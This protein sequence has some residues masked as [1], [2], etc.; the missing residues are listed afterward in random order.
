MAPLTCVLPV[1]L[2]ETETQCVKATAF[3]NIH[4]ILVCDYFKF[5]LDSEIRFS[6]SSV[7]SIIKKFDTPYNIQHC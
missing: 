2:S 4:S 6:W 3:T 1:Q 5:A 7:F